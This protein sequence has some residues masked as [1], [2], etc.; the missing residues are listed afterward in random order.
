MLIIKGGV[1]NRIIVYINSK[2]NRTTRGKYFSL[3]H[4]EKFVILTDLV[5]K[6]EKVKPNMLIWK[7]KVYIKNVKYSPLIKTLMKT[8]LSFKTY[9]INL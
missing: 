7:K 6:N 1:L 8:D 3:F 2:Y 4:V 9:N 5:K